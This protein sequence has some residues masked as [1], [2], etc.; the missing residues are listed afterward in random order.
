MKTTRSRK[1]WSALL[2]LVM[3]LSLLPVS[4]LADAAE[5]AEPVESATVL[6]PENDTTGD[7]ADGDATDG[8]AAGSTPTSQPESDTTDDGE[9]D[10]NDANGENEVNTEASIAVANNLGLE[11]S[12]TSTTTYTTS[13]GWRFTCTTSGTYEVDAGNG[14]IRPRSDVPVQVSIEVS[15]SNTINF[16]V[17]GNGKYVWFAKS[18]DVVTV[19]PESGTSIARGTL[20]QKY[21][22][23]T[24][25]GSISIEVRYNDVLKLTS[26]TV[27]LSGNGD[28]SG[29]GDDLGKM[30]VGNVTIAAAPNGK[31]ANN[32]L[33]VTSA[34][35]VTVSNNG[36]AKIGSTTY[37]A[38]E[39][40]AGLN[41]NGGN[42]PILT[43]G[44]VSLSSGQSIIG[45]GSGATIQNN[46]SNAVTVAAG[47]SET[48]DT[49][50]VPANGVVSV[51]GTAYKA[52]RSSE[53][54]KTAS[55][56]ELTSG[57]VELDE[58]EAIRVVGVP[59]KNT[60]NVTVAVGK[61]EEDGMVKVSK[62][63]GSFTVD[64]TAY[65]AGS[66]DAIFSIDGDGNVAI[67]S[68][69]AKLISGES[70]NLDIADNLILI[71]NEG[72]GDGTITVTN[73]GVVT[74]PANG[75]VKVGGE[76][77][78]E[79]IVGTSETI[80]YVDV[81]SNL[82]NS[83]SVLLGKN[84]EIY[85]GYTSSVT[86]VKNTGD[87]TILVAVESY[88]TKTVRTVTIP[89]SGKVEIGEAEIENTNKMSWGDL[90]V[91]VKPDAGF[92]VGVPVKIDSKSYG[93]VSGSGFLTINKDGKITEITDGVLLPTTWSYDLDEGD[94]IK[95][96]EY[97]YTAPDGGVT[98]KGLGGY[99]VVA[100][101]LK[102]EETEVTVARG[103]NSVT[104]TAAADNTKFVMDDDDTAATKI[105]L[106]AGKIAVDET[107]IDVKGGNKTITSVSAS[108]DTVVGLDNSGNARLELG[109]GASV[110]SITVL[111]KDE[112][113]TFTNTSA[114]GSVTCTVYGEVPEG[115]TV[116]DLEVATGN[117]VK[118]ENEVVYGA[119][120]SYAGMF[121][122]VD[123]YT[124][125][126]GFDSPITSKDGNVT[127]TGVARGEQ[128]GDKST[129]VEIDKTTGALTL[130]G[131]KGSVT[132][133]RDDGTTVT[134]EYK[135]TVDDE[136]VTKTVNVTVPALKTYTIDADN[137]PAKVEK[138][139]VGETVKVGG[140][141]GLG[142]VTFTVV[143]VQGKEDGGVFP[144]DASYLDKI[145]DQAVVDAKAEV[146]IALGT[147]EG[148]PVVTFDGTNTDEATVT[149]T[150]ANGGTVEL[151]A[152]DSFKVGA[153]KYTAGVNGGRFTVEKITA[154]DG[155]VSYKVQIIAGR[156]TLG[157]DDSVYACDKLVTNTGDGSVIV[158]T[159]DMGANYTASIPA[160]G[161]VTI[162]AAT[163]ENP[164]TDK[165]EVEFN[166][167]SVIAKEFPI[168]VD[169][170]AYA[171]NGEGAQLTAGLG[172]GRVDEITK[173]V[174]LATTYTLPLKVGEQ[175]KIGDYVYIFTASDVEDWEDADGDVTIEGRGA[176]TNPAIVLAKN[177]GSVDV[178]LASGQSDTAVYT[179]ANANTKFTMPETASLGNIILLDNESTTANSGV[180]RVYGLAVTV[181]DNTIT[182]M[183]DDAVIML[184]NGKATLTAGKGSTTGTMDVKHGENSYSFDKES[185]DGSYN[186]NVSTGIL[187]VPN[188]IVVTDGNGV[189]YEGTGTSAGTFAFNEDKTVSPAGGSTIK[190]EDGE[191]SITGVVGGE[192]VVTTATDGSIKLT[193]GKGKS[194]RKMTA[195]IDGEDMSFDG[196][197][198][199][200]VVDTDATEPT[201]TLNADGSVKL[202]NKVTFAG[203][204]N[205]WFSL[206][207]I[208]GKILTVIPVDATVTGKN[209]ANIKGVTKTTTGRDTK[210]E[211]D[212]DGALTLI[213]GKGLVTGA[214]TVNA[215]FNI[216]EGTTQTTKTVKV[217]VPAN[218]TATIDL[219]NLKP[220]VTNLDV[221]K[222]VTIDNVTYTAVAESSFPLV[223]GK[224][225]K[226]GEKAV[227]LGS[228]DKDVELTVGD[229]EDAPVV[230]VPGTNKGDTTVE[231][232]D[233]TNEVF[234]V[235]FA[236]KGDCFMLHG[237]TFTAGSN[238]AVFTV[239]EDE[240]IVAITSG[241]ALLKDGDSI[242]GSSEQYIENPANT[243]NDEILVTVDTPDRGKD[244]VTVPAYGKVKVGK[245]VYEA[246]GRGVTLVIDGDGDY[247]VVAGALKSDKIVK[248][249][250]NSHMALWIVVMLGAGS[251]LCATMVLGKK[252]KD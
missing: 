167:T 239:Y 133:K 125:L 184:I 77:G 121:Y 217:S 187:T 22:T 168:K 241:S 185:G 127:I 59:V 224:L 144:V 97:T 200:Y 41:I 149:K 113:K 207:K 176:N 188:G 159:G 180:Q 240:E 130:I 111:V 210:V 236:Q 86:P 192:T 29:N 154:E 212:E 84:E 54:K 88:S 34:G 132:G 145:G 72:S 120:T 126:V 58:N 165:I 18:G 204:A 98:M 190:S 195:T 173:D 89:S 13:A 79:Y 250:D 215:K 10:A 186:F 94:S 62:E 235:T 69:T 153:N 177:Y 47:N 43:S 138:L 8:E 171:S 52:T 103:D 30:K 237:R 28:Q 191:D 137:V 85:V 234:T 157:K 74:V 95:I 35:V 228:H 124:V 25:N 198:T 40:G 232:K 181:G 102:E 60:S 73:N 11:G 3:L 146:S 244:T 222:S 163:I 55:T 12:S 5:G 213:E 65:T 220:S 117:T 1:L 123:D 208:G 42:T 218:T 182:A 214:A 131:G 199:E 194:L 82:L 87:E 229:Y 158:T 26:G 119:G 50:T 142:S 81:G 112:D 174:V 245:N 9:N 118:D 44:S 225:A 48:G 2:A 110:G 90:I 178:R 107:D 46:G 209:N 172:D 139:G 109:G 248:T 80:I 6:Q 140:I 83:G 246:S 36:Y 64:G 151:E 155:S 33:T 75:K 160:S 203:V 115:S 105:E 68:G 99:G 135:V 206:G 104:Y 170:H 92:V 106:K 231:Y 14:A 15:G 169:G 196:D 164:G 122:F 101:E 66:D 93:G 243:R 219:D 67:W 252:K 39:N 226:K 100:V 16:L 221:G 71:K 76:N 116:M 31:S 238:G 45:G 57:A 183:D 233:V 51:G 148:A 20:S 141:F 193:G 37:T 211:I 23:A 7:G 70:V 223:N 108:M 63:N 61:D 202:D 161:S 189:Q 129:T 179:A 4:A 249:G 91:E 143:E 27:T 152:G 247:T 205:N 56:T 197:G 175:I 227:I 166:E 38:G 78:T 114:S 201:L 216:T 24:A 128:P 230:T 17:S 136:P 49:I 251:A 21:E 32:T 156:A 96:G 150:T 19:H 242:I 162:G 147:A 53:I 134:V